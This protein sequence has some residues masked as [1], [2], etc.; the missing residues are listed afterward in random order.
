MAGGVL[1]ARRLRM[2]LDFE[3]EVEEVTDESL[4]EHYSHSGNF[5]EIVGNA[6]LWANLSRQIRLQRA[7]LDDEGALRK[8]LTY[9]AAVEVDP[10]SDSRLCE[11]FG[12]G[13]ERAEEEILGPVFGRLG[14]EDARYFREVSEDNVLFESIEV[15]S[16]SIRVRLTAARIEEGVE[17]GREEWREVAVGELVD[18][19]SD[20]LM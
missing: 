1:L 9:V 5:E 4:R 10:S 8:Y 11:I 13:V 6:V 14:E 17:G 3:A 7:L 12:V 18:R 19:E 20:N 2:T 15:L 16:R